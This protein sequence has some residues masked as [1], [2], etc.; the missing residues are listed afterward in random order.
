MLRGAYEQV[1][2]YP[3]NR[4]DCGHDQPSSNLL[5]EFQTQETSAFG[6]LMLEFALL[7]G[8]VPRL[9]AHVP[10]HNLCHHY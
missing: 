8:A 7:S 5:P 3:D 1:H 6:A 10:P 2:D 9:T 4:Y